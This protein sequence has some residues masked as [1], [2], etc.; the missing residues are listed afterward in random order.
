MLHASRGGAYDADHPSLRASP[1]AILALLAAPITAD[2]RGSSLRTVTVCDETS[3]RSA[4]IMS[5][6]Q[7]LGAA[8]VF[9]QDVPDDQDQGVGDGDDGFLWTAL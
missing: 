5:D 1:A 4:R 8:H 3:A 2:T 7:Q 9:G 6:A